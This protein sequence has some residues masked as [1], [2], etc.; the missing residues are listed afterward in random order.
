MVQENAGNARVSL[1]D[2]LSLTHPKY[3]QLCSGSAMEG[4][5][6]DV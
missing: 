5:Q 1:K 4:E 6:L 2:T 3:F